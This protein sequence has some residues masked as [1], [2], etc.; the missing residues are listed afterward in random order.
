MT[1][2]A[3]NRPLRL[4]CWAAFAAALLVNLFVWCQPSGA[5][6]GNGHSF[7][8]FQTA[9]SARYLARDGFRLDYET[10]VLGPPWSI[11]MEFP[12]YQYT[13]AATVRLTG[14]TLE[15]AGRAVSMAYFWAALPA[16]WLLLRR[17][18]VARETRLLALALLL[19]TPVHL[20]YGR[21]FMIETTALC[22]GLWFLWAFTGLLQTGRWAYAAPA[23]LLAIA[24]SLAKVTTFFGFG[25]AAVLVMAAAIRARPREWR[26]LFARSA[27][28]LLPALVLSILWVRYADSL[29][30]ENPVGGFLASSR[31]HEFNFGRLGQRVDPGVWGQI[32]EI[33]RTKVA[34][35]LVLAFALVG[36]ALAPRSRQWLAGGCLLCFAAALAVFT[37]LFYIHDYYFEATA[38]F[39]LGAIVLGLEGLLTHAALPVLLRIGVIALVVL[40]QTAAFWREFGGQFKSPAP[41]APPLAGVLDRLTEPEEV[42]VVVGQD[43][44]ASLPYFSDRRALMIPSGFEQNR[45][46]L[47]K[48]VSLLGDRRIGALVVAGGFRDHARVVVALSRIFGV[49]PRPIVQGD[50]A[51]IHLPLARLGELP[52]RLAEPAPAGFTV[53]RGY[54]PTKDILNAEKEIDLTLPEW[55]GKFPM[56]SPAP[57]RMTGIFPPSVSDLNGTPVIGTHAP[58][59]LYFQPPAGATRLTAVGGLFPGAYEGANQTDGVVVEVW[60]SLPDGNQHLHFQRSLFPR[61][62]PADRAELTIEVKAGRPFVGPLYLRVDPGLADN[63][64]YD[65]FYWRSVEIR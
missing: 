5:G 43:W 62:R 42:I 56:A 15:T 36:V 49:T 48:S 8:Q 55:R 12:L 65:W 41:V 37:N 46:A 13:V 31:L 25:F 29:K 38:V 40:A 22:A 45:A 54:D 14:A 23:A 11:P 51:Q 26:R 1:P 3:F 35:E 61:E 52:A 50:G 57:P 33:V 9:V 19:T 44:H 6:L 58:N 64:N 60:E 28:V 16:V 47:L 17:W 39:L 30:A 34:T 21:H 10:P 53:D 20:F 2:A 7:R 59:S 24:G 63:I 4:A 32:H 18:G 27:L